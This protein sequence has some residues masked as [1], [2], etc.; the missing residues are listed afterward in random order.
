[1]KENLMPKLNVGDVIYGF[2]D[3]HTDELKQIGTVISK[4]F[5]IGPNFEKI[6]A[7]YVSL[8]KKSILFT[9]GVY[10]EESLNRI[11]RLKFPE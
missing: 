2:K 9:D 3:P 8:H 1:M 5:L 10:P 6:P 7:V 4:T 11:A